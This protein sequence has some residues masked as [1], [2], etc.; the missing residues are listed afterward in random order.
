[1]E[2]GVPGG[3]RQHAPRKSLVAG[4]AFVVG[5]LFLAFAAFGVWDGGVPVTG[6][7]PGG[8]GLIGIARDLSP[9]ASAGSAGTR[10]DAFEGR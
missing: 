1:M 4:I 2:Q 7:I 10:S 8:L 5:V 6:W 3:R 9:V